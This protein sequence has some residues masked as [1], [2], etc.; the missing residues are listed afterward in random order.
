MPSLDRVIDLQT[1][2]PGADGDPTAGDW[3]TVDTVWAERL[4]S[5]TSRLPIS[6]P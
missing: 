1:F 5:G 6:L 4:W 3:A 2:S